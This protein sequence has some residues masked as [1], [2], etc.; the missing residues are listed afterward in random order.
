MLHASSVANTGRKRNRGSGG[1]A[2]N[3]CVRDHLQRT[4]R[5]RRVWRTLPHENRY[6][7]RF[8]PLSIIRHGVRFTRH[9]AT[10][11]HTIE[12]YSIMRYGSTRC[13]TRFRSFLYPVATG[14]GRG[15]SLSFVFLDSS[16]PTRHAERW[17]E[18]EI[19]FVEKRINGTRTRSGNGAR[20]VVVVALTQFLCYFPL[21]SPSLPLPSSWLFRSQV[22]RG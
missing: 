3:G 22:E 1:V 13:H 10:I 11:R 9:L 7:R 21:L 17:R 16:W 12:N 18:K 2:R 6:Q 5:N 20:Y 14:W 4:I 15:F 19:R 8:V